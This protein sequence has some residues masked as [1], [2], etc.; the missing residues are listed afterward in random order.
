MLK[1]LGMA[2]RF[3]NH[4]KFNSHFIISSGFWILSMQSDSYIFQ[5]FGM[6]WPQKSHVWLKLK[7]PLGGDWPG[8]KPWHTL[9]LL[10]WR[11]L[12]LFLVGC[13]GKMVDTNHNRKDASLNWMDRGI[14]VWYRKKHL[15][16]IPSANPHPVSTK[17]KVSKKTQTYS[18]CDWDASDLI[19][20]RFWINANLRWVVAIWYDH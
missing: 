14:T 1:F 11:T 17:S 9:P 15:S 12:G 18:H 13:G 3:V 4:R 10:D 20:R 7:P 6:F 5:P 2:K 16:D 8:L 19:L